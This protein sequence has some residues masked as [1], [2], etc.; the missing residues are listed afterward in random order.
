M[1]AFVE[2]EGCVVLLK[3]IA[4]CLMYDDELSL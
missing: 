2:E 4:L 3:I 1:R